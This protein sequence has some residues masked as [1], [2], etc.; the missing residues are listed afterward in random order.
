MRCAHSSESATCYDERM[1][2]TLQYVAV[3]AVSVP[4]FFAIDMVWLGLVATTFYRS[5]I[6]HLM[7]DA[8]NW[9]VAFAFYF[10][11]LVGLLIFAILP[12]IEAQSFMK[13]LVYGALFG[14]FTY[15][16]YDLTNWSTLRDWP[17]LVSLV[18]IA[19]G[20]FLSASVASVTYWLA[21]TFVL[22]Y[23]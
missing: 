20:T 17:M 8:V 23:V 3:Y 2:T 1:L 5:Q 19:W 10:L 22:K 15:M 18:D 21:V 7:G 11:F 9:P 4:V 16:T 12:A 13:A 6:G 14:F